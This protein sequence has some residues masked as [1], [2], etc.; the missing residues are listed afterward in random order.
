[1]VR[2]VLEPRGVRVGEGGTDVMIG[3]GLG[4]CL[5]HGGS[6][7]CSQASRRRG[8]NTKKKI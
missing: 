4:S 7:L 8:E 3:E 2:N 1:M 5:D 6:G